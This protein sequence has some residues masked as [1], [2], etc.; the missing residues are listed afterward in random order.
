MKAFTIDSENDITVFASLKEAEAS[1]RKA[2]PFCTQEELDAL[3][4]KWRG[5]RLIEIWN[6]LPGVKPVQ[7]FTSRDV[8]LRRIWA[9]IQHLKPVDD[10]PLRWAR[11]RGPKS[12]GARPNDARR[13]GKK[14]ALVIAMLQS[15][16]GATLGQIMQA[17]GWQAHTVRGFVSG[18]LKKKLGLAVRSF[19]RDGD[20]V[21]SLK[22]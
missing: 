11:S 16:K 8:A 2:D 10:T 7:K 20:R 21:Y 3:A 1:G 19:R 9:A 22:G 14:V 17:T 13:P 15:S 5:C 6:S 12:Q 18:Q 4:K